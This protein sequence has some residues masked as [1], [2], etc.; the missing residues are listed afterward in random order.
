MTKYILLSAIFLILLPWDSL[1][2]NFQSEINEQVWNVQLEAMKNNNVEGFI[3]VMSD[4][5]LQVSYDGS[6]IRNKEE[7]QTLA[8]VTYK[9]VLE[10]QWVRDMEFR[11]LNRIANTSSAFEDGFFRYEIL[12]SKQEK[13]VFYGY[14]QVV[15]RKENGMWKVLLDYDSE[16]FGGYAG[17]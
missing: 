10:K 17:D 15:L 1:S 11:F 12:N 9:R 13:Q 3:S 14:F 6:I 16:T 2:Q 8:E 5:V 7:F 4:E